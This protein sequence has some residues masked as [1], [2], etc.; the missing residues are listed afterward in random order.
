MAKSSSYTS[1]IPDT[2]GFIHYTD[3]ENRVWSEL[4]NGQLPMLGGHVCQ[5][6]IEALNVMNFPRDRIPQLDEI[7]RVLM[8]HTGWSVVAVP[9]L[10]DFTSFF[11]LLANRQSPAAT[12]IRRTE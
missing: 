4:I 8:D 3:E 12:F 2:N 9:A 11:R 7:S 10:I 6:Y 5:E 1:K